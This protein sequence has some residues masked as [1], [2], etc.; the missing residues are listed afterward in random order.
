V[1]F[2]TYSDS[3]LFFD[4]GFNCIDA[5][6]GFHNGVFFMAFKDERGENE[7]F[8]DGEARKP[9]LVATS[10][11]LHG[12]WIPQPVPISPSSCREGHPNDKQLW[13]EAPIVFWHKAA[14]EWWVFYKYFRA[15][16]YSAAKS[17]DGESW[18]N[19]DDAVHFP[20]L[21]KHGTVFEVHEDEII[22]K[23]RSC[24]PGA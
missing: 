4:P 13:A 16:Q 19:M 14:Q 20:E 7:V 11:S 12:P 21:A 23:L 6:F 24:Q 3:E 18:Q 9:I 1:D 2:Q 8:P 17:A 10:T 15:K 22:Q 5:S